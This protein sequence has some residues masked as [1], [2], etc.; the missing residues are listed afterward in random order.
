MGSIIKEIRNYFLWILRKPHNLHAIIFLFKIISKKLL[1]RLM[2]T[3]KPTQRNMGPSYLPKN[4]FQS[5]SFSSI[6]IDPDLNW[7]SPK[8]DD[9]VKAIQ[10]AKNKLLI[11]D[12]INWDI[13]F[14]DKEELF[15]LHRFNWALYLIENA[16][17]RSMPD[18]VLQQFFNWND[19]MGSKK[20]HPAWES[21]SLSERIVNIILFC[22]VTYNNITDRNHKIKKLTEIIVP[23]AYHLIHHL[24]YKGASTNNHLLNNA[25]ALYILGALT[26]LD[27][28]KSI[29]S[30]IILNEIPK[31]ITKDGFLNE[32]SSHYHLLL[33]RSILEIYWS[34]SFTHDNSMTRF[35]KPYAD[36]MLNMC[37]FF[38]IGQ[39]NEYPLVGDISPDFCVEWLN[40]LPYYKELDNNKLLT[41]WAGTFPKIYHMLNPS[42]IK[43]INT[44]E[45]LLNNSGWFRLDRLESSVFMY[46]HPTLN[47]LLPHAHNDLFSFCLYVDSKPIVIDTGRYDYSS[48]W[49]GRYGKTA[50][51]HSTL[52][53]DDLSIYPIDW[54]QIFPDSYNKRNIQSYYSSTKEKD[55]LKIVAKIDDRLSGI[56]TMVR[57]FELREGSLTITDNIE[58]TGY[59]KVTTLFQFDDSCNINNKNNNHF[60]LKIKNGIYFNAKFSNYNNEKIDQKFFQGFQSNRYGNITKNKV[61]H[62]NSQFELPY[63]A[64]FVFSWET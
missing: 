25:R 54:Y 41:G 46:V 63:K 36:K 20:D 28:V 40:N 17:F 55:R 15:S 1:Q 42:F 37:T 53:V 43:K 27:N 58:G 2:Y 31:Q 16:P 59:H 22:Q 38:N 50:L 12:K 3:L 4:I 33:T 62:T 18:W 57:I 6:N 48:N 13:N 29:G 32:G 45:L 24:E 52:M 19:I 21:Y 61:W 56:A 47:N 7:E 23:W 35:I 9:N 30:K 49:K 10:L 26:N 11:D 51:A 14:Q 44:K 60:N 5:A 64:E 34:A 8:T 39:S